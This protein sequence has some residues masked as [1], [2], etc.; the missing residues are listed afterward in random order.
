MS[1]VLVLVK[2]RKLHIL[3]AVCSFSWSMCFFLPGPWPCL[4]F[5]LWSMSFFLVLV[6]CPGPYPTEGDIANLAAALYNHTVYGRSCAKRAG[7]YLHPVSYG[8][9]AI[10]H[11]ALTSRAG[12]SRHQPVIYAKTTNLHV[13]RRQEFFNNELRKAGNIRL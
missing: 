1:F 12:H 2:H 9:T 5:Q 11:V 3:P 8:G 10:K 7:M 13:T 6:F 4:L